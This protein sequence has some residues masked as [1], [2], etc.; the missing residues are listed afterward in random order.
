MNFREL[1]TEGT[2]F[3]LPKS[4]VVVINYKKGTFFA[5]D[6]KDFDK[7][8]LGGKFN[9]LDEDELLQDVKLLSKGET[10]EIDVYPNYVFIGV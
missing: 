10:I 5:I 7:E 3:K 9:V 8:F 2:K 1:I 4:G 6:K